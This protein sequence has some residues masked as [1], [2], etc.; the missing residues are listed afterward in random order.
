MVY[1]CLLKRSKHSVLIDNYILYLYI[2]SLF[3]YF[4]LPETVGLS[5]RY[6]LII[7]CDILH[8]LDISVTDYTNFECV[9]PP[10]H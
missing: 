3:F 2:L 5:K 1:Y 6:K 10:V 8:S 7:A 9:V 4:H